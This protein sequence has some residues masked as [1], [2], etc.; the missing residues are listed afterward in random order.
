M[1]HS[2]SAK[3]PA[4]SFPLLL[5]GEKGLMTNYARPAKKFQRRFPWSLLLLAVKQ[6]YANGLDLYAVAPELRRIISG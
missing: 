2:S 3:L 4:T 5:L 6:F 1:N